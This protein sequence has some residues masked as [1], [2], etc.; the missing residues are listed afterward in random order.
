[1]WSPQTILVRELM[2]TL[3]NW[4][5]KHPFKLFEGE[6]LMTLLR[7]LIFN[8]LPLWLTFK[9]TNERSKRCINCMHL[10][11]TT[12]MNN[13]I[14]YP[15]NEGERHSNEHCACHSHTARAHAP[16]HKAKSY[17]TTIIA[18][19]PGFVHH[20]DEIGD[21]QATAW[22]PKQIIW[23]PQSIMVWW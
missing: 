2:S 23:F 21:R 5:Y 22:L 16:G 10:I 11:S 8:V 7:N 19:T 14:I 6:W 20:R 12:E 18:I 4:I 13:N 17:T 3:Q 9:S 1:M 15:D